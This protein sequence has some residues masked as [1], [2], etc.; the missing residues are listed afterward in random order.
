VV[1]GLVEGSEKALVADLAPP[2][3]RGTA[4]G[5]YHL[6]TGIAALPASVGFGL[7]WTRVGA[8]AAFAMGGGL[9][10]VAATLLVLVMR[11]RRR[12]E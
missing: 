12:R 5:W 9:A 7:V 1:F 10:L 6:G 4:F 2:A 11:R 8:P 3:A